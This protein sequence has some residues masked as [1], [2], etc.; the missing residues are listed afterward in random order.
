MKI[1]EF[2]TF[3]IIG[4]YESTSLKKDH[5]SAFN[6]IVEVEK[7]KITIEKVIESKEVYTERLQKLW[8]ECDNYHHWDPIRKK[9]LN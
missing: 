6:G 7:Y 3:R 1:S 8:E 9:Q 2:E 5:I 4:S